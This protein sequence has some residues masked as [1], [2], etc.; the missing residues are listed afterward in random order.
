ME[1]AF[2]DEGNFEEG[3]LGFREASKSLVLNIV[4]LKGVLDVR[5]VQ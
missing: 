3:S 1:L 4:P 5:S 2:P